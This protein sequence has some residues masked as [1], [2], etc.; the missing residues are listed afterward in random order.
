MGSESVNVE[1][2]GGVTQSGVPE[3]TRDVIS[4]SWGEGMEVVISGGSIG[5]DMDVVY[6][7]I[8]SEATGYHC[9]VYHKLPNL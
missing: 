2:Y 9:G 8:H 6:E 5:G 1:V 7:G 3:D 4:S